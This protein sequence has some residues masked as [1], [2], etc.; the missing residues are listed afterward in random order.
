MDEEAGPALEID[1]TS[2]TLNEEAGQALES[3]SDQSSEPC[4]VAQ[5]PVPEQRREG[6]GRRM[7]KIG[8]GMLVYV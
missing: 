8:S 4:R 2:I 7:W 6:T 5:D 3:T 1:S